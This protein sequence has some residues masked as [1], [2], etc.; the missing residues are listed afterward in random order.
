MSLKTNHIEVGTNTYLEYRS[1]SA[2]WDVF[3][4]GWG[5]KGG[6]R[7]FG[8]YEMHVEAVAAALIAQHE[9]DWHRKDTP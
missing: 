9:Y 4:D 1:D 6:R 2:A 8:R 7:W 5:P 3:I